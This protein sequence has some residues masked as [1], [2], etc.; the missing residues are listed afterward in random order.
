MGSEFPNKTAQKKGWLLRLL[1]F[2]GW[3]VAVALLTAA[4]L[5]FVWRS[6]LRHD[7]NAKT[8]AIK[9]AGLPVNWD[10]LAKWPATVPDDENA[11]FIYTNAIAHL[12]TRFI[13]PDEKFREYLRP[14]S[15]ETNALLEEMVRTNFEALQIIDQVTNASES[16]Y[17]IN[18]QDGPTA[19]LPHLAG[20]NQLAFVL[21]CDAILKAGDSNAI[22]ATEDVQSSL[23]LSES[24]DNEPL[25]FSQLVSISI[26]NLSCESL[27]G[28]LHRTSLSEEQLSKLESQL[29]RAE[30]T[31][32]FLT[33]LIGDRAMYNEF[34][35]LAQDDVRKMAEISNKDSSQDDQTPLPS[36]NPG[37]VWRLI[38][39]WERDRN[40]FLGAMA[41]N[42]YFIQQGPPASRAMP[43]E[44][45]RLGEQAQ[46]G[47][48]IFSSMF[49]PV[50]SGV[51]NRDASARARLRDAITVLAI[52][53]WR[54]QHQD[55]VP[56]SLIDLVPA[57]LPTVPVDPY[58]G[59]PLRYK[60][61]KNGYL[62]YSI[63][64]NL[65]DD[66]GKEIPLPS[67]KVSSEER[68]NYDIVFTVE[69]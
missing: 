41:T 47:L 13:P 34:I 50:Y 55:T 43:H 5:F 4:A 42:I 45:D 52:E 16:R 6:Q 38:G 20:L 19:Q 32:R 35:R 30:A 17:P 62:I 21:G 46:S 1:L 14:L 33:A 10:D 36:R 53:R 37:A 69:R 67:A 39:F 15:A 12:N 54:L 3:L 8:A 27:E 58:D 60:K 22:A 44:D 2:C 29:S 68:R 11:A 64:P 63:G 66:G 7:I 59:K 28:V 51:A 31:N 65:K 25:L 40:F 23:K 24:L 48:Y 61:L 56:D 49:L 18:Y 26:L 57:F 9:G